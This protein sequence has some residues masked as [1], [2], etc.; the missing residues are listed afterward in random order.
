MITINYD[1]ILKYIF[2]FWGIRFF[3]APEKDVLIFRK[4]GWGKKI[5]N[6]IE[7]IS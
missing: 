1:S 4:T 5:E 2:L 3:I 7:N 6:K